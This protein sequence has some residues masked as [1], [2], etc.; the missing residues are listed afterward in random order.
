LAIDNFSKALKMDSN[1]ETYQEYKR[2]ALMQL[3]GESSEDD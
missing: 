2:K 3:M 1:N